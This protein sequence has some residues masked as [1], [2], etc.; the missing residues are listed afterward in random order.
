MKTLEDLKRK[1][2][3]GT[4]LILKTRFGKEVNKK[5]E[6]AKTQSNGVWLKRGEN[7][8]NSWLDYPKA[9]LLEVTD[10]GF[11]VY[12]GGLRPL[13]AKEQEIMVGYEKIRD[14]K[15]EE[16]DLLSDGSTSY[17]QKVRYYKEHKA[18]YLMGN[19]KQRGMIYR[20]NTKQVRDDRVKGEC[21]L[22]YVIN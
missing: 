1:L 18:E 6:V 8:K 17:W 5:R 3:P 19:K 4:M 14:K 22:E 20:Y 9:S 12:I 7:E 13:T 2:Q 15:Q 21:V 11:K 16:I 10:A